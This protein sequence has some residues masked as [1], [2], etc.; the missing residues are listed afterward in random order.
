MSDAAL[1]F[2]LHGAVCHLESSYSFF[3]DYA[4]QTLAGLL[5]AKKPGT[6][7]VITSRLHWDSEPPGQW[8]AGTARYWGRR[9]LQC[10]ERILQTEVLSVPGL[11]LE[12]SGTAAGLT[13]EA[14]YRPV[15]RMEKLAH[16]LNH[17]SVRLMNALIYYLVYFPVF[18][19]LEQSRGWRV[20]HAA[21]LSLPHGGCLL[22]GLPGSGKSTFALSLLASTQAQLLSDN[23]LLFDS[24]QIYAC[25]E[26]IHLSRESQDLLPVDTMNSLRSSGRSSS[27]NRREYILPGEWRA[28]KSYPRALFFVGL[29]ENFTCQSVP[30]GVAVERLLAADQMAREV[31][32]YTQFASPL[33]L[34]APQLSWQHRP[35]QVSHQGVVPTILQ[36]TDLRTMLK[37]LL[38]GMDCYE[39]WLQ[40]G[41][42][43]GPAADAVQRAVAGTPLATC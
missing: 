35:G 10:G 36:P 25:P 20:L 30:A 12:V 3:L 8:Q 33:R 7:P 2:S 21:G 41:A 26:T 22:A 19:Y 18:Y 32:A 13:L 40:K 4:G 14:Y 37:A 23:L 39:L 42:G 28:E 15:A 34:V 29:A 11:Q 1:S 38:A 24:R 43:F 27:F 9:L 6:P 5:E 16:R 31:Q 17:V